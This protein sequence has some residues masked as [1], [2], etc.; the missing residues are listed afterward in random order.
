MAV[1]I[2]DDLVLG[3]WA[4]GG[5]RLFIREEIGDRVP[6]AVPGIAEPCLICGGSEEVPTIRSGSAGSE[7][8]RVVGTKPCPN[9]QRLS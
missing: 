5:E 4:D 3:R 1:A 6:D 8:G 9:C 7:S 2:A